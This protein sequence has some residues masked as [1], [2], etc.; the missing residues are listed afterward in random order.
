MI[1]CVIV[2][3]VAPGIA[4]AVACKQLFKYRRR[5]KVV[6]EPD[7]AAVKDERQFRIIRNDAVIFEAE[8]IRLTAFNR[9]VKIT[10]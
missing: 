7:R 4:P 2:N 9:V 1:V 3:A 6:R 5:I 10:A 8:S